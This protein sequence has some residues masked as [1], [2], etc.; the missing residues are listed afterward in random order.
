MPVAPGSRPR[1]L[2]ATCL[3]AAALLTACADDARPAAPDPAAGSAAAPAAN[4]APAIDPG[5]AGDLVDEAG[6]RGLAYRNVSGTAAKRDI[7]E[8]NGAGVAALDLGGDGDFDLV[9]AQGCASLASALE[10]P[11]ADLEV[12]ENLGNGRFR[13]VPG[14]GLAGWWPGLASGDLDGDGDADLV[15]AGYGGLRVLLQER[16]GDGSWRL[17]PK[18]AAGVEPKGARAVVPGVERARDAQA[19]YWATS[20]AR[21]DADGDGVLDLYVG[22]YVDLDPLAPPRGAL[23][24]PPLALPCRW[25]GHE[26]YCGPRGMVA[27]PDGFWRGLGD[28]TFVDAT[29]QAGLLDI[30]PSAALGVLAFDVDADGDTDL[31]VANDSMA[32]LLLLN[33][34]GGRFLERGQAAGVALS[35]EGLP[36]AGMG[37]AAGDVD[38]DGRVDLAVTNFSGEPTELFLR[39]ERGFRDETYLVGLHAQTSALLS[40]S[41][42]LVDFDGD[43]RLD[44]FTAN[45]HVYPQADLPYTGTS[46]GQPDALWN[47]VDGGDGHLRV[48]RRPPAS[49]RSL[50]APATGSRGAAIADFDGDGA[51]D[52]VVARIDGPAALGMNRLNADNA[53]LALRLEGS[54]SLGAGPD[55][56]ATPPEA[57]GARVALVLALPAEPGAQAEE[58]GLLGEVQTAVGYQSASAPELC[59]GLGA[60]TGYTALRVFWPSGRIA[61]LLAGAANRRLWLREGEAAPWRDEALAG[62]ETAR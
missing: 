57:L 6:A 24:E 28:G 32:N 19:P 43:A 58:L 2:V 8:A 40:W 61:D 46:Y 49:E 37:A 44:L 59:F 30:T 27:Q 11:G 56:R 29:T 16:A 9:F 3:G 45:G 50:L 51:P 38:H 55:S 12:F 14:P 35:Q 1:A 25:R 20:V 23:G 39:T 47:F 5:L 15:A 41:V 13:A 18:P 31:Y 52:I 21:F 42:H 62:K 22:R 36:E 10:G 17:V 7:L 53:R 26:V 34:G 54:P 48:V 33:L 60:R 4:S